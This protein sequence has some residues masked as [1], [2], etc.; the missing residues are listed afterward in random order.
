MKLKNLFLCCC[1]STF[2]LAM[3]AQADIVTFDSLAHNDGLTTDHGATYTE[4]GFTF[5]NIAT[6]ESSGFAPSLATYGSMV[7]VDQEPYG[8]YT[9]ST[10]L[11]N[12]NYE[13][14]TVLT[15]LDGNAFSFNSIDLAELY[16]MNDTSLAFDVT[17]TGSF[18]DGS[19]AT[20]TVTLDNLTGVQSYVFSA[21]SNVVSVNWAQGGLDFHQFDNVN[22]APV[23]VPAAAWLLGSGLAGLFGLRRRAS[24]K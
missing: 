3:N 14:I 9:G 11:I 4:A 7:T 22:V 8:Y 20:Q 13:G 17:F 5:T 16:P 12:N 24:R 2:G 1:I 10:A 15:R 19:S 23:P 21:F 6:V 18:A